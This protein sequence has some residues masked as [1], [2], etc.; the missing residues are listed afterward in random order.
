M[1]IRSILG[2]DPG[3]DILEEGDIV[4]SVNRRATPNATAYREVLGSLR[5]GQSAWLYVH[6]PVPAGSFLTRVEVERAR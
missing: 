1:V 4:V 6:R 5:R 3:A 2:V